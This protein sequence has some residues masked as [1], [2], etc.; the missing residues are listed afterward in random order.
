MILMGEG[1]ERP[2]QEVQPT[3]EACARVTLKTLIEMGNL[4]VEEAMRDYNRI[5]PEEPWDQDDQTYERR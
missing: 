1:G 2:A 5:Q 3:I 4:S